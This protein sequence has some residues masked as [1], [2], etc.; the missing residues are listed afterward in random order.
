MERKYDQFQS[1]HLA[2]YGDTSNMSKKKKIMIFKIMWVIIIDY[3]GID[4]SNFAYPHKNLP[5][6][7]DVLS[8][9]CDTMELCN[10]DVLLS[11]GMYISFNTR[12]IL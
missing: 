11:P 10:D 7:P 1:L 4:R 12:Y 2:L 5:S 9:F 3:P 8:P 6:V